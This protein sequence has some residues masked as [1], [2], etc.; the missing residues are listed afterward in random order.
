MCVCVYVCTLLP[1]T[2]VSSAFL[3]EEAVRERV[4]R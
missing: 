1:L 2:V 3:L 4:S